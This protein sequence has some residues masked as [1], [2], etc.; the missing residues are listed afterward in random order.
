MLLP[1]KGDFLSPTAGLQSPIETSPTLPH[2]INLDSTAKG[3]L[4]LPSTGLAL[5]RSSLW[6][7]PKGKDHAKEHRDGG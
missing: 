3:L 4:Y 6:C 7:C 2:L 5:R 1:R